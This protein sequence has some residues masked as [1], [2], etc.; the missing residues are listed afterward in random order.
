MLIPR[1]DLRSSWLYSGNVRCLCEAAGKL[2]HA[3]TYWAFTSFGSNENTST[4]AQA[5]EGLVYVV[6]NGSSLNFGP[7]YISIRFKLLA[8]RIF[9]RHY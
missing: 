9:F 2:I 7:T 4:R 1:L 5:E 3:Q 8:L 6:P